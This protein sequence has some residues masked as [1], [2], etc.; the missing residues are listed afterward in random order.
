MQ[1]VTSADPRSIIR[2]ESCH[3]V[4]ANLVNL[5]EHLSVSRKVLELAIIR[6][7]AR[8]GADMDEDFIVLD[9]VT[10]CYLSASAALTTCDTT[11]AVSLHA[12]LGTYATKVETCPTKVETCVSKARSVPI[13]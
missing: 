5:I 12:L 10:P 3:S 13:E 2:D 11:L 8:E 1:N 6:E 9:D 7:T 4:V